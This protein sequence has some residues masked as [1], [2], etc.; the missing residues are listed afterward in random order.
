LVADGWK[1]GLA[2]NFHRL[3]DGLYVGAE[4][5]PQSG[6]D[7]FW[8]YTKQF[9]LT[10]LPYPRRENMLRFYEGKFYTEEM[11]SDASVLEKFDFHQREINYLI[12]HEWWELPLLY[13]SGAYAGN[14]NWGLEVAT[15]LAHRM[16]E[17]IDKA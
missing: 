2:R 6:Y 11:L 10:V 1:A 12:R 16:A 9:N 17:Q 13:F 14:L 15:R 8:Q 5:F 3:D 7:L 4:H